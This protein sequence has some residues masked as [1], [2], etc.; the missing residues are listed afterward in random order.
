MLFVKL[1]FLVKQGSG[2]QILAVECFTLQGTLVV[3]F[4]QK[5]ADFGGG[6][7]DGGVE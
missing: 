1:V 7:A 2:N 6:K 3:Y 5:F 4:R